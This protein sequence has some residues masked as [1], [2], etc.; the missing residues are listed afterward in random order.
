MSAAHAASSAA[1]PWAQGAC[2]PHGAVLRASVWLRPC[3]SG[4]FSLALDL[5][6]ACQPRALQCKELVQVGSFTTVAMATTHGWPTRPTDG[7]RRRHR[8]AKRAGQRRLLYQRYN[9]NRYPYYCS[10]CSSARPW[11]PPPLWPPP[12][13]T[14]LP[15]C[16]LAKLA[17]CMCART[18]SHNTMIASDK[19][20]ACWSPEFCM[21]I[22]VGCLRG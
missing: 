9:Y 22:Q 15:A 14:P 13:L 1:L 18:G 3:D 8:G 17:L 12:R 5:R 10:N 11:W 16:Q 19:R 2:L 4:C 6:Q 21:H 7:H 20:C